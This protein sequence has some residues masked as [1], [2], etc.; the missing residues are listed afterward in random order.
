ML[1]RVKDSIKR[2]LKAYHHRRIIS[3]RNKY[4]KLKFRERNKTI[5]KIETQLTISEVEAIEKY[6]ER[7]GLS[8]S[9]EFHQ[10]YKHCTK[11]KSIAAQ[12][13][14]DDI[15]YAKIDPFFNNWELAHF[16]DNKTYYSWLFHNMAQPTTVVIRQ[17]GYWLNTNLSI[18]SE[19]KAIKLILAEE[20]CFL[21]QA[22]E[23][24]GGKNIYVLHSS[25]TYYRIKEIINKI[26]G[27]IV[28][29]KGLKQSPILAQLNSSSVNTLRLL[30]LLRKDGSVKLCSTS[31]RMGINGAK[32][33]N[34]SSGG[35]TVGVKS[36]GTLNPFAFSASGIRYD[37][38]PTSGT[39][40]KSI[41]IPD[42]AN[43]VNLVSQEAQKHP[44]FRL[45]SWDIALDENNNPILIEANLRYGELEFH[46]L[47]NGP[48]FGDETEVILSEVFGL[49][50]NR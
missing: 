29:Q 28:V 40:F 7:F 41:T 6:Y 23:S 18:I 31:L 30:T 27:D 2:N 32:V 33:D 39:K 44:H 48:V 3:G 50:K 12:Y 8:V 14:P 13:I 10:F 19:D 5:G 37:E 1:Q 26:K 43:I 15:Y 11:E 38:H 16:L 25:D 21:K 35:I 47:N 17:N 22:T 36:D 34:A 42:F 49:S 24:E 9:P 46:Q 20:E 45:I 4:W